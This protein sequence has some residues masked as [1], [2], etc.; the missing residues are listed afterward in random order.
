MKIISIILGVIS[1]SFVFT[2]CKNKNEYAKQ[3]KEI[4]SLKVVLQETLVNFNT[5]D[6][7]KCYEEDRK[8]VV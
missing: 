1:L 3:V 4:D 2:S 6:S 5:I 7:A 8:S